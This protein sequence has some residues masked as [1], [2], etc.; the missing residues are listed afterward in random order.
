MVKVFLH[1]LAR[2]NYYPYT[3]INITF[4]SEIAAALELLALL[5]YRTNSLQILDIKGKNFPVYSQL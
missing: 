5:R 1:Y 3:A 2:G 4:F